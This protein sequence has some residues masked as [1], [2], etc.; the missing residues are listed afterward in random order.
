MDCCCAARKIWAGSSRSPWINLTFGREA[1]RRAEA[2]E[3]SRVRAR[4]S[5]FWEG[6]EVRALIRAP[7]CL[8]VA[9]VMR[10]R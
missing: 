2:L 4:S 9:P 7:P 1:R 5:N 8:P 10:I 6:V 3:G